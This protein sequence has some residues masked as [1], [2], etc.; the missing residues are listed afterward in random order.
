MRHED[1]SD[2]EKVINYRL[3]VNP[4]VL[5]NDPVP[6]L[7]ASKSTIPPKADRNPTWWTKNTNTISWEVSD[8]YEETILD[9]ANAAIL[10]S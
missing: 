4:D 7:K 2:I 6:I 5:A 1:D 10:P 9:P 8:T 3:A